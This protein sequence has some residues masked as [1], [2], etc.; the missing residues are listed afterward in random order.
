MYR[1][2][3]FLP[4]Y[5]RKGISTIYFGEHMVL[6][7]IFFHSQNPKK[8]DKNTG[9]PTPMTRGGGAD[10]NPPGAGPLQE[11]VVP[12]LTSKPGPVPHIGAY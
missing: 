7:S 1:A 12:A 11:A 10:V 6:T 3:L 9:A 2:I 5:S 8:S 4:V